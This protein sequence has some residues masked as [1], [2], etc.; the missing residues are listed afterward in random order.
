MVSTSDGV[1]FI[2]QAQVTRHADAYAQYADTSATASTGLSLVYLAD[3]ANSPY[4]NLISAL[5]Y[6]APSGH[7]ITNALHSLSAESYN[8]IAQASLRHLKEEDRLLTFNQWASPLLK[9]DGTYIYGDVLYSNFDSD[10]AHLESDSYSASLGF[11]TKLN[12][13]FMWGLNLTLSSLSTD[14]KGNNRA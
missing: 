14:V 12:S 5:D 9:Q 10:N 6:S 13:S 7:E 11:D 4:K 2:T 1:N 3:T 8:A